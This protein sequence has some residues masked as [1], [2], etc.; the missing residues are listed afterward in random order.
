MTPEQALDELR[1]RV[2]RARVA[3]G[4]SKTALADRTGQG[5]TKISRTTVQQFFRADGPFPSMDTVVALAM[6]LKLDSG[7]LLDL[8]DVAAGTASLAGERGGPGE[9]PDSETGPVKAR[10]RESGAEPRLIGPIPPAALAYQ[11]RGEADRLREVLDGGGTAVLHGRPMAVTPTGGVLVGMGGVGKSQLAAEYV[12][13]ALAEGAVDVVVWVTATD[14]S[15]VVDRFAEA[16]NA[17]CPS[18]LENPEEAARAF[19][20]WLTPKRSKTPKEWLVVLDDLTHPE[21]LRD[22]WPPDS[23]HGRTLITTRRQDAALNRPGRTWLEIGVFTQEQA[24]DHLADALAAYGR[25][26]PADEFAALAADLGYLPLALSQAA[27]YLADT[28]TT[29]TAYRRAL[30]D[31]AITLGELAPDVLPDHQS[32]TVAAAWTLSIDHADTLRPVG[33]ARPLLQLIACLDPNG[34]PQDVLTSTPALAY[35][36]HHRTPSPGDRSLLTTADGDAVSV[37]EAERAIS[38]LR[39][40]SLITHTPSTAATAVR[41]HQLLQLAVRDSLTSRHRQEAALAAADALFSVW[42]EIERDTQLAQALRSNTTA[43]VTHAENDLYQTDAHV[44]LYRAGTS[45]GE[46]GQ[47]TAACDYYERLVDTVTTRLGEGHRDSL[48]ARGNLAY[49]QGESGDASGAVAALSALLPDDIGMLGED[50][51][52]TLTTRHNLAFWRGMAGDAAGAATAFADLLPDRIRVLG[53]DHPDTLATRHNIARWRG[54]AGDAAGAAAALADLLTDRLRVLGE[55][56]RHTLTSRHNL[57]YWRGMAGDAAAATAFADLLPDRIRVLGEDHPD[58]LTTRYNIARCQGEA[59]DAA[60]AATAFAELLQDMVRVLGEDHPLTLTTL[61]SLA[62]W[63]AKSGDAAGAASA[64]ASLLANQVRVL[65]SNHPDTLT[66]RHNAAHWRGQSGDAAGAATAFADLFRDL[67]QELGEDHPDTLTTRHNIAYWQGAAGD[68]VGARTALAEVLADRIR[69]LGEDHPHTLSARDSLAHWQ[70]ESG[71]A[72][73]AARAF[74]SLLEDQSRVLGNDHPDT[75][76]TLSALARW[77]AETGDTAGA[78]TAL[79]SL[80]VGQIGTL[81]N[82]HPDTL[83][84]RFGLAFFHAQAGHADEAIEVLEQVITDRRRV[85]GTDHPDTVSAVE[86]MDSLQRARQGAVGLPPE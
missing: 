53:E 23:P 44:V 80:L 73:G 5:R 10:L 22:L 11:H 27:A 77:R 12:R 18:A 71:D 35:L 81:G 78:T 70:G 8:R 41:V 7:P 19:M 28:G 46:S 16:G 86:V 79:T 30:A 84:T 1:R 48:I 21:D 15:S 56:H 40:L 43:L 72:A 3:A 52:H 63:R 61:H 6:V 26:E 25:T 85:L 36:A 58:T 68:A 50:D 55:D 20:S 13:A 64:F 45:L 82:D 42:P 32:H 83:S 75:L 54:E 38:A 67:V 66:T 31:R 76:T 9:S 4:L 74:A 14:R 62:R 69:V 2:D 47:V 33:L 65:G 24:I 49:W 29:A 59:G 51:P 57:A 34:I 17:L 39:R 37:A 60:G